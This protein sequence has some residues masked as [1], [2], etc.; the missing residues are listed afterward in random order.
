M[1]TLLYGIVACILLLGVTGCENTE[2]AMESI[3]KA[4]EAIESKAEEVKES[5]ENKVKG[6]RDEYQQKTR[7]KAE[8]QEKGD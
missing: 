6:L 8:D 3:N 4:K 7:I 1:R 5:A 2:K